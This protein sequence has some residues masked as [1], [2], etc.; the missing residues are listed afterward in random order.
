[1]SKQD[2][3][4]LKPIGYVHCDA[5]TVSSVPSEGLPSSMNIDPTYMAALAGLEKGMFIYVIVY[6]H[7]ADTSTLQASPGT[8][9]E[10]GVFSVRSSCRPNRLGMTLTKIVKI[11]PPIID[12]EWLDFSDGTPIIDIKRYNW[13]WECIFSN[14]RDNRSHFEG[15]I[16]RNSLSKV[17]AR[18][19]VNFHGEACNWVLRTSEAASEL[20]QKHNVFISDSRLFAYI[21]GN[22]HVIDAIQGITGASFGNGRLTVDF[23][24]L[25]QNCLI[26]IRTD[27][28]SYSIQITEKV[29][30]IVLLEA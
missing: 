5:K 12:V 11:S 26:N 21:K 13:R 28:G 14:P 20:V 25:C 22:G 27:N 10:R 15:L 16:E 30:E 9:Q 7:E 23:D 18:P 1:M 29:Y 24:P 17:L 4:L 6:L 3:Y 8:P 19:A 2:E